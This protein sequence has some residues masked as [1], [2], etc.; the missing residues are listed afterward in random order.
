MLSGERARDGATRLGANETSW[1]GERVLVKHDGSP[2]KHGGTMKRSM[3]ALLIA[4]ISVGATINCGC[5]KTYDYWA[6]DDV[7]IGGTDGDEVEVCLDNTLATTQYRP[8]SSAKYN[9]CKCVAQATMRHPG[10][11]TGKEQGTAGEYSRD[12]LDWKYGFEDIGGLEVFMG[13]GRKCRSIPLE[14]G[15]VFTGSQEEIGIAPYLDV[16]T[17]GIDL[18]VMCFAGETTSSDNMRA[19]LIEFC[20]LREALIAY[21]TRK[22]RVIVHEKETDLPIQGARVIL[23][24]TSQ[25][26]CQRELACCAARGWAR[27]EFPAD[28]EAEVIGRTSDRGAFTKRVVV[29]GTYRIRVEAPGR[30]VVDERIQLD[31][32]E[33]VTIAVH[34]AK[35]PMGVAVVDGAEEST[36]RIAE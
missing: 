19:K 3:T 10:V 20:D 12:C 36:L 23:T 34:L 28:W 24:R 14:A 8:A 1:Y 32:R 27:D 33:P 18:E 21:W 9:T 15:F 13:G 22:M 6:P 16:R 17:S 26:M 25:L 31:N 7:T 4:A 5:T 2:V 35:P 11:K 30:R 29:P